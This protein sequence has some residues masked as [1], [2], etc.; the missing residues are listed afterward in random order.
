LVLVALAG[1][2]V[3]KTHSAWVFAHVP[4]EDV[5]QQLA[6]RRKGQLIYDQLVRSAAAAV[7]AMPFFADRRVIETDANV[8]IFF[9]ALR[10]ILVSDGQRCSI[11]REGCVGSIIPNLFPVPCAGQAE[12]LLACPGVPPANRVILSHGDQRLA[13]RREG[14][15]IDYILVPRGQ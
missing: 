6:I 13:I 12:P 7:K 8:A 9:L 15:R 2:H 1:G 3:P 4:G 10:S 11:R 5:G 14:E